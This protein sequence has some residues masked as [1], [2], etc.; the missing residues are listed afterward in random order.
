MIYKAN[1]NRPQ[2]HYNVKKIDQV[3]KDR[4]ESQEFLNVMRLT[5]WQL[6]M[7]KKELH[8]AVR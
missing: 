4:A 7:M 6:K 5:A 3:W 1:D 2:Y 8:D